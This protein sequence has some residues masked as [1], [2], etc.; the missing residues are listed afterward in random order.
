MRD[1]PGVHSGASS[2][3]M[4]TDHSPVDR[5][6]VPSS[7]LFGEDPGKAVQDPLDSPRVMA[8]HARNLSHYLRELDIQAPWRREM[9]QDEA[10][11]DNEQWEPEDIATI[12]ARG[13]EP[14]VFNVVAQSINWIIG[15]ERRGRTDYKILP[16]NKAGSK[17]AEAKT[18]LFKYLDQVNMAEFHW[19]LSFED[20]AKAGLG[21]IEGGLQDEDEGEPIYER[22]ESWRNIIY[23][24]AAADS[25]FDLHESRYQFRSK[26]V[27]V[28]TATALFPKRK[29]I[30]EAAIIGN[31]D[32]GSSLDRHGDEPM[33]SREDQAA[34]EGYSSLDNPSFERNRVRL[35]EA[36]FRVPEMAE[37]M[38]GGEFAGEIY[39]PAS[40]GHVEQ[41]DQGLA[42]VTRKI[43]YR[44]Y[45][46][47][48][49]TTGVLWFSPS[50]YRHNRY[51][52][53]P[54]W[55]Y[56]RKKDGA[57]YGAIRFMRDA[58]RDINKR[59]SKAQYI[60]NSQ[61]I[62]MDEGAVDDI[63]DLAEEAARPDSIIVKKTGKALDISV[64]RELS[65]AHMQMMS[66]SVGMIQSLSGVTDESMG[67]TTNATSGKAIVAR[68]EQGALATAPLFDK[69]RMARQFHGEKK[70]SLIEQFMS[71]KKQFRITNQ[72]G[73]PS[74]INVN[75][76]LPEN[77]IVRSKADYIISEDDW[78][79]SIR[80]AQ[81]AE[82][83][84]IVV[85][86]AGVAPNLAMT[87]LDLIVDAMDVPNREEIVK[88]IRSVTGMEDPDADPENPDPETLARKE[89][90]AKAQ[91]L[92]ERGAMAELA[93]VEAEATEKASRADKAAAE[94][95]KIVASLPK[96]KLDNQE[97]AIRIAISMLTSMGAI[98]VADALLQAVGE[99]P[100]PAGIEAATP[101][102][103]PAMPPQAAM[104]PQA[105]M[106]PA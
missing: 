1:D 67:R 18:A 4:T 89:A 88:R 72:R 61:K 59:F 85:Q 99:Q 81:V 68:Q 86:L 82:L 96:D 52:F 13:Q 90:Q 60:L 3:P 58:Q 37:R 15:T 92:Q 39:D 46:M 7:T 41:V 100:M 26:W 106:V 21:W 91:A 101:M 25:D 32:Y 10:Y 14:V 38:K 20:A 55:C 65:A 95:R 98:D 57:P 33:D 70:L 74:Y 51:P 93:K 78:S 102:P 105:P 76:G 54:I 31:D 53:T 2:R 29:H 64:D 5:V 9:E 16:R 62:I 12:K 79:A 49:T 34:R 87:M 45:V 43:T 84:N 75:D 83:L 8:L 17:P 73:T 22:A 35:V 66:T 104:A 36:W 50:P 42:E 48:M 44:M 69:L 56:R 30:I 40:P 77:D 103:A 23:D 63:D 28:D 80:Q 24:S 71:Q 94:A 11:Y 6:Q 47:I 97:S 27:D 19:S